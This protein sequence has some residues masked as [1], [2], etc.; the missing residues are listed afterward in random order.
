MADDELGGG[1]MEVLDTNTPLDTSRDTSP[2]S[3]LKLLALYPDPALLGWPPS[4]PVEL[5]MGEHSPKEICEAYDI[6]K[7][8]FVVLTQNPTFQ[9]A[10]KDAQEML[11]K[12]GMAF[13]VKARMQAE[14]LL[15]ESWRLIHSQYTP[16]AVKAKLIEATWRVAGFEPKESD[17]SPAQA[18][19]I[20]VNLG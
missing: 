17:R 8:Q 5:A 15:P 2:L 6:T 3:D 19:Q 12:E 18:L 20:V 16:A 11:A 7:A 13:R 4:L 9:K 10:F 1:A 14:G